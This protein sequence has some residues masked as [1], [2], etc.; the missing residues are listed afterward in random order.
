MS[1]KTSIKRVAL[2]AAAALTIGGFSAVSAHATANT[3]IGGALGDGVS[4]FSLSNTTLNGVAGPANFVKVDLLMDTQVSQLCLVLAQR[5][6][7]A[8]MHL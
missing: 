1:T 2:V 8:Q 7:Q 5:L 3:Y 6:A 4:S